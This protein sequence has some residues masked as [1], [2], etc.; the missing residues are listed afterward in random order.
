M[1]ISGFEHFVTRES[2]ATTSG[3]TLAVM[4]VTNALSAV[5]KA[6]PKP[7][8]FA[9]SM[10]VAAILTASTTNVVWLDW[11]FTF[12]NGCLIFCSAFGLNEIAANPPGGAGANF[13]KP[14][15]FRSWNR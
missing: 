3:A 1:P 5:F 10:L 14:A 15:R 9:A 11:V 6:P 4:V 2:I 8:A 13:A 7:T 12:V